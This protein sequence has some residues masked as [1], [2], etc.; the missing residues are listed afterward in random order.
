MSERLAGE[1][2][3]LPMHPYLEEGVQDRIVAAVREA[4]GA[5][6]RSQA[7]E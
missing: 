1:V 5:G 2:I 7:A 3:S 4:L 6:E